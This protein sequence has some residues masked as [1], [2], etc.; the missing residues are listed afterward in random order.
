MLLDLIFL[1]VPVIFE[2]ICLFLLLNML[3]C[4]NHPPCP[5]GVTEYGIYSKIF[6]INRNNFMVKI[7]VSKLSHGFESCHC[8]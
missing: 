1:Y 5:I 6:V 8:I 4:R 3:P 2:L 7:K